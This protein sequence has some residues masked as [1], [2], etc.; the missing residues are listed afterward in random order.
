[1]V[2][3]YLCDG[4]FAVHYPQTLSHGYPVSASVPQVFLLS[5]TLFNL[6]IND[7]PANQFSHL[8]RFVDDIALITSYRNRKF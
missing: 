6:Y 3:N 8:A 4:S 1:M 7:I 2:H 5:P